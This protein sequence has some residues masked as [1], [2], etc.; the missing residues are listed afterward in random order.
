[1]DFKAVPTQ[2]TVDLCL[3]SVLTTHSDPFLSWP[4]QGFKWVDGRER[5]LKK[6]KSPEGIFFVAVMNIAHLKLNH[7][8]LE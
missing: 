2:L 6:Q 5:C 3:P 7:N 4:L 8:L 1:M